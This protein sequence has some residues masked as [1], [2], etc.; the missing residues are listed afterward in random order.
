MLI[1]KETKLYRYGIGIIEEEVWSTHIKSVEYHNNLYGD[2]NKIGSFFFFLNS[3]TR[4]R[5]KNGAIQKRKN[6]G[7]EVTEITLTECELIENVNVMDLTNCDRP[8]NMLNVLCDNGVDILNDSFLKY[9]FDKT[10]P[11]SGLSEAY[12]TIQKTLRTTNDN[13]VMA[14][15]GTEIDQ[16]FH[17]RQNYLGQLLT[18][19]DNGFEF[20]R[21]LTAMGYEGYVFTEEPTSPTICLFES[22]KLSQPIHQYNNFNEYVQTF[23]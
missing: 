21:Q 8:V 20:K 16:F 3:E 11:F 7:I 1:N 23:L 14:R 10:T 5:V 12:Q 2:K 6:V 4:D 17:Y 9:D 13:N 19:F 15:C 22:T 18:D